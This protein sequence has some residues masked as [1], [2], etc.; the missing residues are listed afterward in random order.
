MESIVDRGVYATSISNADPIISQHAIHWVLSK[1]V[2]STTRRNEIDGWFLIGGTSDTV[3]YSNNEYG[4]IAFRGSQTLS[5]IQ[6]D[7]QLSRPG[8]NGCDFS[9]L[10]QAIPLIE[11]FKQENQGLEI[12]LTGHS[13]GGS[14]AR[15]AGEKFGLRVVTFNGASPPSNP[16]TSGSMETD[17]HIIFDL[18]SAWQH[19]NTIRI[20]KFFRPSPSRL[21]PL[22][23]LNYTLKP[24]LQAHSIENFS[25]ARTG[26]MKSN[27]VENVIIQGW[28]S[29]LYDWQK[30]LFKKFIGLNRLPPIV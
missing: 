1:E 5:D 21:N 10:N 14:I 25:N 24:V 17:Y 9:K 13:L 30:D 12:Q 3:M 8:G 22:T 2:Y 27:E 20:D 18:I 7:I 4:I 19:P 26:V 29:R 23:W 15:C 6:S 28:Y 16:V 11:K